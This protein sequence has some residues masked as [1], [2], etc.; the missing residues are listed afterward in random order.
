[1]ELSVSSS[2]TI[3]YTNAMT[4]ETV[5]AAGILTQ[6][7]YDSMGRLTEEIYAP[8]TEYEAVTQYQYHIENNANRL[9]KIDVKEN[10]YTQQLNNAGKVTS[11]SLNGQTIRQYV[12]DAFG[13]LT[14]Q[15]DIDYLDNRPINI[16]TQFEYNELGQVSKI[17]HQDGRIEL[18]KQNPAR[19][20]NLYEMVGLI[21]IETRFN[22]SGQEVLKESRAADGRLI[23][24]TEF[25]YDG[26][27]NLIETTDTNGRTTSM[28]Y[29]DSNRV[30][31]IEKFIDN[32]P[33]I[34]SI[35]YAP[36]TTD[37]LVTEIRLNDYELG[38]RDYDGL[39][40]LIE[41]RSAGGVTQFNYAEDASQLPDEKITAEGAAISI[42]NDVYLQM[43]VELTGAD[44]TTDSIYQYDLISRQLLS[45]SNQ[46][47]RHTYQYNPLGQLESESVQ[48]FI[49]G[50]EKEASYHSSLQGR[51]LKKTDFF[52]HETHYAYDAY[53][54]MNEVSN[55]NY[56]TQITYDNYSRPIRFDTSDN[57]DTVSIQLMLNATGLEETRT[58]SINGQVNFTLTQ[59]YNDDLQIREKI[60]IEEGAETI[61]SMA[62]DNLHRLVKYACH[63]PN[64]PLDNQGN[65]LLSQTFSYDIF[66][67]ITEVGTDFTDGSFNRATY[68]YTADNPVQ[69]TGMNN[70]H[71]HYVRNVKFRYDAAGNLLE[72][73]KGREYQYNEQGQMVSIEQQGKVLSHYHYDAQGKVVSQTQGDENEETVIE[74]YYQGDQLINEY[75]NG[76]HSSYQG[77]SGATKGRVVHDGSDSQHQLLFC[78][79]QGS[80]IST[81]TTMPNGEKQYAKHQYTPYG[82]GSSS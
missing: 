65:R 27:G 76:L 12:Y 75:C 16:T 68:H 37:E 50:T 4:T 33:L 18:T 1:D 63:G 23:A 47:S 31:S 45:S 71:P 30:I 2:E 22:L 34:Q 7:A 42:E 55:E 82:E 51:I 14:K 19:L 41:E 64:C 57:Q 56:V 3:N 25:Q 49:D 20:N 26:F 53:G 80:V 8:G 58:V 28:S 79:A 5:N 62:Y 73:E 66:S 10:E 21:K 38:Q 29:D 72:D 69:L 11:E 24:K 44:D 39:A 9:V 35:D 77:I 17:L 15:T 6:F 81:L 48:Y 67:N 60:H 59:F 46:N 36:F 13:F 78:N 40:R 52:D 61:E 32:T 54:R 70:S 43:P 74:L